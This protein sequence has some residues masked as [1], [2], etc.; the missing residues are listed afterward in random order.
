MRLGLNIEVIIVDLWI[1]THV[2]SARCFA[3]VPVFFLVSS[4]PR[5]LQHVKWDVGHPHTEKG[6]LC[7]GKTA[8]SLGTHCC[9]V[10]G[11]RSTYG[12]EKLSLPDNHLF[13][14][15]ADTLTS[16]PPLLPPQDICWDGTGS[17]QTPIKSS[18]LPDTRRY[19]RWLRVKRANALTSL[20]VYFLGFHLG[21]ILSFF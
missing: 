14:C 9:P 6:R 12:Q 18:T 2:Q 8:L 17:D 1:S 15:I 16:V 10:A 7:L 5:H 4:L 21:G 19:L 11:N 20:Q 3:F 13:I